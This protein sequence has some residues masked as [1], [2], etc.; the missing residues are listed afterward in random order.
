MLGLSCETIS[1]RAWAPGGRPPPRRRRG[2]N[3]HFA[4]GGIEPSVEDLISDPVTAAI[5]R[6]DRVSEADLRGLVDGVRA[7]LRA[8]PAAL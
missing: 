4:E 8:R 3:E 7:G 5:M 1:G 2:R 6:C